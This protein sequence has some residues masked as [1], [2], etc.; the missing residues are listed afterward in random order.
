M[1]AARQCQNNEKL[2]PDVV[3]AR[4]LITDLLITNGVM[5]THPL[6]MPARRCAWTT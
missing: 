4:D 6:P 5:L 1:T 3:G 2:V